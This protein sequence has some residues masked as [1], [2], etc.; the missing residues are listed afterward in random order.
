MEI[1]PLFLICQD[2]NEEFVFT[3]QAQ[4]YFSE[5][6]SFDISKRCKSCHT[7]YKKSLRRQGPRNPLEPL[8]PSVV[9]VFPIAP[10]PKSDGNE[11]EF[12]DIS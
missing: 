2:C 4:I 6:G 11:N 9:P 7:I 12:P 5:R 10:G 8:E 1:Q 3:I